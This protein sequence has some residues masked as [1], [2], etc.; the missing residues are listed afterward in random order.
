MKPERSYPLVLLLFAAF[1]FL[2]IHG[3]SFLESHFP[4]FLVPIYLLGGLFVASYFYGV[5]WLCRRWVSSSHCE[6]G[7]KLNRSQLNRK[8]ASAII[9]FSSPTILFGLFSSLLGLIFS[10]QEP[11]VF[12]IGL[13]T[14]VSF[15]FLV[16]MTQPY[17]LAWTGETKNLEDPALTA[18][19]ERLFR[20]CQLN[21]LRIRWLDV[22]ERGPA[23]A[24]ILGLVPSSRQIL[25][26]S[27]LVS[28]FS[29]EEIVALVAHEIGHSKKH[30]LPM[31]FALAI[32]VTVLSWFMG[33]WIFGSSAAVDRYV[34]QM[35]F[36][37][38][39]APILIGFVM[40]RCEIAADRFACRLIPD[41]VVLAQALSKLH[42]QN[43]TSAKRSWTNI[44]KTHPRLEERVRLILNS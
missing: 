31:Y 32:G 7:T 40:R 14:V 35:L 41:P 5:F 28:K 30:H 20:Q 15:L 11:D 25:L 42:E 10:K 24:W 4:N 38:V 17:L 2:G 39:C 27:N 34:F 19:T 33:E 36:L 37:I 12:L 22:G 9:Y 26:T 3:L 44:F 29:N 43:S 16:S 13:F 1:F 18:A 21:P 23:N 8:T 6:S